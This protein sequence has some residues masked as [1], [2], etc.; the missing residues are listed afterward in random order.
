[1]K[2]ICI[3][4]SEVPSTKANSIQVMKA[5]QALAE[6][7]HEIRLYVPVVE[8]SRLKVESHGSN[9]PST[10]NLSASS[11]QALPTFYG[12]RTS[13][14]VEWLPAS[15]RLRRFDFAWRAVRR[16][17][18]L[19]A[20]AV[21]VWLP[22]AALF[23]VWRELPVLYEL[24]GPPE[25]KLGPMLFRSFLR[26]PVKK[27][28]L[29]ITQALADMLQQDYPFTLHTPHSTLTI[30]PNGVDLERYRRLPAAA[31]A[32]RELGLPDALTVGYTGH[33]YP[34]RGTALLVE[35]AQRFPRVRFLW[36][37]GRPQ[38]VVEWRSRLAAQEIINVKLAGFVENSRLP[39]YQAACD[40]LLMPYERAISG[41]SGG[42]SA[43]YAS[44]MK[45]FEY[46]ACGRAV[47][48][49][50]LPVIREVL[51]ERNAVLCPPED[52][53]AWDR[54]LAA[55]LADPA[56]RDTLA[57]QALADVQQYTWAERA[58][59]AMEGFSGQ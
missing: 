19:E 37:G 53:D 45:M 39:G 6:L 15:P 46:M 29:P 16:A 22:Q 4:A 31:D 3:S 33:L 11:G 26:S 27:R 2:I 59:R 18:K 36:V 30:S 52:A 47:I 21:Y 42:N 13:F 51:N 56:K 48:S 28:L 44:P 20:D 23:A 54:A 7:G 35:L 12:L 25:G 50:D 8:G 43:A 10:F 24:H 1:M 17:Q 9:K 41:S 40:V 34:G 58:R 14:P 38:D 55:L 49:S 32:R 5:C 57:K